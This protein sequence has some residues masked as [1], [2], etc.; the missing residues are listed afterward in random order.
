MASKDLAVEKRRQAK[1]YLKMFVETSKILYGK[2]YPISNMHNLIHLSNDVEHVRCSIEISAYSFENYLGKLG[3]LIRNGNKPL[4]QLC[5]RRSELLFKNI[6]KATISPAI[7]II[8]QMQQDNFNNTPII[9]VRLNGAIFTLKK[10]NNTVLLK[11][12][13]NFKHI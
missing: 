12:N 5:R 8:K 3:R 13:S 4:S 9:C 6:P 10:P 1:Y 2:Q 11:N 7:E